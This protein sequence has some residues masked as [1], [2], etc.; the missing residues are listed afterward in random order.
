MKLAAYRKIAE[1]M[2][3]ELKAVFAKYGFDTRSLSAKID[4]RLGIVRMTLELGDKNHT[5]ESG[6]KVSPD[7]AYYVEHVKMFGEFSPLKAEWLND[8]F[9]MGGRTYKLVGMKRKG[10]KNIL[11][12]RDDGKVYVMDDEAIALHFN[13]KARLAAKPLEKILGATE[14]VGSTPGVPKTA[15]PLDELLNEK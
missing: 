9:S 3:V 5:N 2:N 4:E 8:T 12:E 11:I 6:E 13:A 1:P 15:R 10:K 14:N 7:A